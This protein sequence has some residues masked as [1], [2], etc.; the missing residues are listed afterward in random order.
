MKTK[1]APRT[2]LV[3]DASPRAERS[4]SRKLSAEYLATWR[5]AHPD[6]KII[7]RDLAQ[8]PPPFVSEAWV[9]GAF[10]PA[11][12]Q[13]VAAKE[14]I[15]V[16]N[17]YVDELLEADD[18]LIATPMFN[19]NLPAALKAWIDQVVRAGR[20]FAI[21]AEGYA[22]LAKDKQATVIV[23]SGGDFRPG[24]PAA[25]YDFLSPYVRGILGFIGI[26]NVEF[27]YAHSL[28][29][30]SAR[31]RSLAEAQSTARKLAAA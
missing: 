31:E 17:R 10:A 12:S 19:L 29:D 13:P 22:G 7:T 27:I 28:S 3:V 20:T 25:G 8:E 6:G 15:A 18:V 21:T 9:V 23:T 16:S 26:N 4:H 2:L 30:D 24:T 11:D 14:A 5:A 1:S